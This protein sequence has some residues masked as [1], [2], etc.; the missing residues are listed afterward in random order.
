MQSNWGVLLLAL[1]L[2]ACDASNPVAPVMEDPEGGGSQT[3]YLISLKLRPAELTAGANDTAR[4]RIT[5]RSAT[6]E[7]LPENAEVTVSTSLGF[8]NGQGCTAPQM[9]VV[10]V[11]LDGDAL[12]AQLELL[13][14]DEAGTA[15]I[16]ASLGDSIG[17]ALLPIRDPGAPPMADFQFEIDTA[18]DRRV[19]F[20]DA[21][22]GCPCTYSWEFGD[23]ATSTRQ[24]PRHTYS[25]IGTFAVTLTVRK[26]AFESSKSQLV[27]L[28]AAPPVPDFQFAIDE[29][30]VQFLNV[31]MGEVDSYLWEFG[32]GETSTEVNP[33]HTYSLVQ[34]YAVTLTASGPGGTASKGQIVSL[35][36]EPPMAD[37]QFAVDGLVVQFLDASMGCPCSYSWDFGDGTF[38]EPE[39]TQ[40]NPRHTYTEAATYAVS[41]TVTAGG[42]SS[43]KNQ[44]VEVGSPADPQAPVA[45]FCWTP[46]TANPTTLSFFDQSTNTPAT[47]SWVFRE[48]SKDSTAS[49][50]NPKFTFQAEGL[51][52]VD[53]LVTN[54]AGSGSV[55]QLVCVDDGT[56]SAPSC[57]SAKTSSC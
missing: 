38:G 20:L 36:L 33:E 41:L 25:E 46:E 7:A 28:E 50:Q 21:S 16:L 3:T 35:E 26:G 9:C 6:G 12:E 53:L 45:D 44:L 42:G 37:F 11:S 19:Q 8:F 43:T 23:G 30:R 48:P 55:S 10:V 17:R 57:G 13:P 24:N 1:G 15:E 22:M 29:L 40:A 49:V 32:D 56:G 34:S 5:V 52:T 14:G 27:S 39:N 2:A 54:E 47:W 51:Y 31:T 18:N 4:V